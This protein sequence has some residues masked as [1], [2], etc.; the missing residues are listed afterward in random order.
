MYALYRADKQ[1]IG[2]VK[3]DLAGTT[4]VLRR[5]AA[6][7]PTDSLSVGFVLARREV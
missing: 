7:S 1:K 4:L 2:H 3:T 5:S 6:F